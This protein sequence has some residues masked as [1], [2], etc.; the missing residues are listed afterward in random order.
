MMYEQLY[1]SI[2][3]LDWEKKLFE[4]KALRRLKHL[5]H[6]GASALIS[7][8]VHSR[9]D[10]SLGVWKLA[11]HFFPEDY[12][13]RAAAIL[14]DVG[15]IPF[16]HS[17]EQFLGFDHHQLT[18]KIICTK[19][20]EECL[21][22]G[23]LSTQ[24]VIDYLDKES[25]LT[26]T[27]E[28]LG[29]DH[30]ESFLRDTYMNGT[31]VILPKE[32]LKSLNCTEAGIETDQET[33]EYIMTLILND[34]KHFL[35]PKMIA[36]DRLIAEAIQLHWEKSEMLLNKDAFVYK[37]DADLLNELIGSPSKRS[38]EITQTVLYQPSRV[39]IESNDNGKGYPIKVRKIY[40]DVPYVNG[41]SILK[42][43]LKAKKMFEELKDLS[44][45][46]YVSV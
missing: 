1:P 11:A 26:G 30:L 42:K 44:F 19:E 43:S 7:P 6:F 4:T 13:S 3:I 12:L 24:E 27:G 17:A 45:Q 39:C 34:H 20:I 23:N 41:E 38:R 33:A 5:A 29:L 21:K 2:E 35:S 16:S 32:V 9:L 36:V 25:V 28:Q 15:H 31:A 37:P 18:E 10:H 22:E 40:S 46:L 14:H 8:V